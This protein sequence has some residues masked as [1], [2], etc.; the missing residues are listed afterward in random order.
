[1]TATYDKIAT[2]TTPSAAADY[3]F[4][5]IT[6]TYTD[7]ICIISGENSTSDQGVAAQV[8]N[9]SVDTGSN[10]SSTYIFGDGATPQSGRGTSASNM[11]VGRMANSASNSI[12]HFMNYSNTTTNK[13]VLGRGNDGVYVIQHVGL[14]RS[15]AAINTIKLFN[16]SSVTFAAG[17]TFT[18]YG[19]KAA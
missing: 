18:L 1:V 5:S 13:T 8:G 9:G 11:L 4:T 3:T 12:I 19:I 14:W 7:L 6:G 10:Y 2:Y 17:V 16:L 15:T